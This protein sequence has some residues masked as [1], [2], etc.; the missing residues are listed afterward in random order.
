MEK[1][2]K[3]KDELRTRPPMREGQEGQKLLR[4]QPRIFQTGKR[5][6]LRR[7]GR[8]VYQV[9]KHFQKEKM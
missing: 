4:P 2:G 3:A 8:A 6:L 1:R 5:P 9:T 7:E